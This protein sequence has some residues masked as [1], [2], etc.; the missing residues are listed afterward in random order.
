MSEGT[1]RH[2]EMLDQDRIC[3]ELNV[4]K[5]P[6]RDALIKLEAEGFV[7]I[8]PRRGVIVEP[9][10][11]EYVKNAYDIIGSIEGT[12]AF[13]AATQIT[14]EDISRLTV[15][16]EA[17]Y[18]AL[19]LE[20]YS[21]Y[22]QLNLEFHNVFL[23]YSAGELH[24]FVLKPIKQRLYDFPVRPYIN[25]WELIHLHEHERLIDS[26]RKKNPIAAGTIVRDEHW[27]YSVHSKFLKQFYFELSS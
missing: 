25:E 12:C 13:K 1:L 22:N 10:T 15:L 9:I 20:N 4:S 11:H 6:L 5:A 23:A 27:S 2:G 14:D 16:N 26:F 19:G 24:D 18:E 7:S 3:E 17:Q 21:E 8:I